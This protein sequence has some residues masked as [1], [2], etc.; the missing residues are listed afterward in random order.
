MSKEEIDKI[1]KAPGE[2]K[3]AVFQTDAAYVREKKGEESLKL[4]AQK[5]KE[6]GHP[7]DYEKASAVAWHPVGLR[8]LS[9]LAMKEVFGWG[10]K[11][12]R[13][14]GDQAPKF[15]FIMK[16]M[17]RYFLSK[18]RGFRESPRYWVMHYNIGSLEAVELNED[19]GYAIIRV[20]DFK[21]HPILCTYL[22][23]F[24]RRATQFVLKTEKAT[25]EET[26]C[27]FSSDPYHEFLIRF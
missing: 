5:T 16:I 20:K 23:G 15:S 18:Q 24:F 6:W 27:M 22:A 26:K 11:E 19:K 13:D 2:V 25:I 17:A 9:L 4:L 21:P 1:M 14:L 12:I 3:G 7:I 10:D 8:V